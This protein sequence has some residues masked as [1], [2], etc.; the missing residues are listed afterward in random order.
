MTD[1]RISATLYTHYLDCPARAQAHLDGH[2]QPDTIHT[3][4]GLLAHRIFAH[5]IT[6]GEI[7]EADFTKTARQQ[8]GSTNL[9][10]KLAGLHLKPAQLNTII[11][12]VEMMYGRWLGLP[13][14]RVGWKHAELH[15]EASVPGATLIG[16]IDA[17]DNLGGLVDWKTGELTDDTTHQL[18]FYSVL[19]HLAGNP[20]PRRAEAVS[21]T[22]GEVAA[23][24]LTPNHVSK[25]AL[26]IGDMITDL[27][28]PAPPEARGG[29]WCRWCPIKD[30]CPEGAA[31]LGLLSPQ[32]R[33]P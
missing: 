19:H 18:A 23:V 3:F 5:H 32:R 29:P 20:L 22:T 30:E 33:T 11:R 12:E 8:I 14:H 26:N 9:N 17:I 7:P 15:E 6:N 27:T 13:H 28:N 31:A 16:R 21:V 24:V 10:W 4:R 2:Y 1:L 25:I